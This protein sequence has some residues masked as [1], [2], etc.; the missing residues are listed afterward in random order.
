MCWC[1]PSRRTPVCQRPGCVPPNMAL[2][3][4]RD[5]LAGAGLAAPHP[6]RPLP[7][8]QRPPAGVPGAPGGALRVIAEAGG[9]TEEAARAMWAD[10]KANGQLLA[11]C[12]NHVFVPLDAPGARIN[13]RWRCTVCTGTVDSHA[14]HWYTLGRSHGAAHGA[15]PVS[16]VCSCGA[17]AEWLRDPKT[18]AIAHTDNC[19]VRAAL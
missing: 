1:D 10:A 8:F 16:V 5:E 3:A 12:R 13:G 9:L 4:A 6:P 2:K 19:A 11:S 14:Q 18:G 15:R 7:G 17:S